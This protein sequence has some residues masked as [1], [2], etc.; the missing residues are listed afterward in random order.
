MPA[1]PAERKVAGH[2]G[3]INFSFR[4]GMKEL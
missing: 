1:T 2:L 4:G 3:K